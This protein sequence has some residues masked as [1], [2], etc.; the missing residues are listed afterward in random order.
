[1][2]AKIG[3]QIMVHPNMVGLSS[4]EHIF[5]KSPLKRTFDSELHR[6]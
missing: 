6:E 3:E 4:L 1:M 5:K 2:D